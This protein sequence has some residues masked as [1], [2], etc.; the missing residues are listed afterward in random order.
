MN[1][2]DVVQLAITRID[3]QINQSSKRAIVYADKIKDLMQEIEKYQE[4]M[5]H[6]QKRIRWLVEEGDYWE[7]LQEKIGNE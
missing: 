3:M 4:K 2:K 6:E 5:R 7:N 1:A